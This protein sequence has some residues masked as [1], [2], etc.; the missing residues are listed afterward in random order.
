MI[1]N[2]TS[3]LKKCFELTLRF[4]NSATMNKSGFS[5]AVVLFLILVFFDINSIECHYSNTYET[6]RTPVQLKPIVPNG[7]T[8][9]DKNSAEVEKPKPINKP[10]RK[11]F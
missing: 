3:L 11:P 9:N 7:Q 5:V 1:L 4:K 10:N 8:T 2:I 6:R